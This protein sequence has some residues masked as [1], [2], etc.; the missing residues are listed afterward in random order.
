VFF[1]TVSKILKYGSY[2]FLI[3]FIPSNFACFCS[4]KQIFF[5][6]IFYL[7]FINAKVTDFCILILYLNTSVTSIISNNLKFLFSLQYQEYKI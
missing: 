4:F 5:Y 2:I 3:I 7:D 1:Y 6:C